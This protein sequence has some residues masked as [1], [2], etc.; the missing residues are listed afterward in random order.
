MSRDVRSVF[1]NY[2]AKSE[3]DIFANLDGSILIR[4]KGLQFAPGSR[5][6]AKKYHALLSKLKDALGVYADRKVNIE[7]HTD[8]DGGV[9]KK[10][11]AVSSARRSRA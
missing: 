6:V 2:L 10:S 9:Q 8:N 3:V 1:E 5:E 4:L 7:G 11:G